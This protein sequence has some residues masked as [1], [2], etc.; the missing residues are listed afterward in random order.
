MSAQTARALF[1]LATAYS[2]SLGCRQEPVNYYNVRMS[3]RSGA[4]MDCDDKRNDDCLSKELL[5]LLA[6][7]SRIRPPAL[8]QGRIRKS[9]RVAVKERRGRRKYGSCPCAST[10]RPFISP[11]H[12]G[13]VVVGVVVLLVRTKLW[14]EV[15]SD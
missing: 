11:G 5:L 1:T 2:S 10:V 13:V 6:F 14:P 9:V 3:P 15:L 4:L 7:P 8:V 12:S